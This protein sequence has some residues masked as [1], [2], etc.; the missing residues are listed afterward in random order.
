[1]ANWLGN[2]A[3]HYR[4]HSSRKPNVHAS[5]SQNPVRCPKTASLMG[6]S[7]EAEHH[8]CALRVVKQ[9]QNQHLMCT[10]GSDKQSIHLFNSNLAGP[11]E[12]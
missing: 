12:A 9:V 11:R 1:M 5:K 3:L 8:R 6:T 4:E 2:Q 10:S 7:D